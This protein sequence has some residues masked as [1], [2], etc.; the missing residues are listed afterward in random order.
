M[1]TDIKAIRALIPKAA[2][3]KSMMIQKELVTALCNEIEQLR[4][5]A[6]R[7]HFLRKN[8]Y[9]ELFCDSPRIGGWTPET[10]DYAID[11]AMESKT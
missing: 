5:D 10:L 2:D 11:K 1:T 8:S 9:I 6:V 7:Y 4:K 3:V